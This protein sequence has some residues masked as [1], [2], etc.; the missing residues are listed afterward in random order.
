MM[1]MIVMIVMVMMMLMNNNDD[2][3]VNHSAKDDNFDLLM[4]MNG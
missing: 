1:T 4:E 2:N 3:C